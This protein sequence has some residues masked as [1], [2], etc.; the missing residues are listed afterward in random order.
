MKKKPRRSISPEVLRVLDD[1]QDINGRDIPFVNNVTK[2]GGTFDRRMTW[3]HHI[4]RIVAK[5]FP[6]YIKTYS[7]SKAGDELQILYLHFTK[8]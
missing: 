8:L 5:A 2:F 3:G 1:V 4:E 7:L 6:T